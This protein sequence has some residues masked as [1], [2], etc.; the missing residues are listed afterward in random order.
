VGRSE[1]KPNFAPI[2]D[3]FAQTLNENPATTVRITG[4]TDSTGSDAI[5]DPL[6]V[7][8][9]ASTRNHLTARGQRAPH[10]DRRSRLA[11][12]NRRQLTDGGSREE[13]PGRD[14]RRPGKELIKSSQRVCGRCR[15]PAHFDLAGARRSCSESRQAYPRQSCHRKQQDAPQQIA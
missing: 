1:I 10:R 4:H 9:A 6:S 8:R 2:L 13:S 7:N 12:T 5:N 15:H 11:R 14:L 3:K